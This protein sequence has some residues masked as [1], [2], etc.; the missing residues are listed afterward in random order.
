MKKFL[1]FIAL[2]FPISVKALA[3]S[4]TFDVGDS[5]LVSLTNDQFTN[6]TGIE[7]NVLKASASGEQYVTAIYKGSIG[8]ATVFDSPYTGYFPTNVFTDAK[9]YIYK[10]FAERT[11]D[12]GLVTEKRLLKIED[13]TNLGITKSGEAYNIPSSLQFLAPI[14]INGLTAD[15]YNYWT[16]STSDTITKAT[17]ESDQIHVYYVKYNE[18]KSADTDPVATVELSANINSDSG[19]KNA[20]RPVIVIDKKYV[21]CNNS[22]PAATTTVAPV[23]TGVSDYYLPLALI[24]GLTISG[25]VIIRKKSLFQDL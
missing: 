20:V 9:D 1:L 2:L 18:T 13:L 22:K 4:E 14:K 12:W 6:Q 23:P 19:P 17:T 7:F 10:I 3:V 16:M 11:A 24:L 8:G 15:E 25:I 21:L 5:I